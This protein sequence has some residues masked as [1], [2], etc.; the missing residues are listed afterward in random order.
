M[1]ELPLNWNTLTN[2]QR[3]K[4]CEAAQAYTS[5]P[6]A[7]AEEIA[8]EMF[9]AVLEAV[10]PAVAVKGSNPMTD[11][12]DPKQ[13][14]CTGEAGS[15]VWNCAFGTWSSDEFGIE[16]DEAVGKGERLY[17]RRDLYDQAVREART[18]LAP[19]P[20]SLHAD[21]KAVDSFADAMKRKL[22]ISRE[23]KS[24]SGW[25]T[26]ECDDEFLAHELIEHL[27]K[28]NTGTF[29]DVA[30]FAMMLHQRGA[31][32]HELAKAYHSAQ[33]YDPRPVSVEDAAR[34]VDLRYQDIGHGY[35]PPM[36]VP[37]LIASLNNYSQIMPDFHRA[38]NV[39]AQAAKL[40]RALAEQ[41]NK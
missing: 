40:L 30:N 10:R 37:N 9:Y 36:D 22:K 17:V 3:K 34:K 14:V 16:S 18:D 25:N 24:K 31:S 20:A 33:A 2:D 39:M 29:E 19:R 26:S 7:G 21:D 23:V 41:A 8:S 27:C 12:T 28:G 11:N 15:D 1:G 38:Q 13:I 4:I 32:P 35:R 5:P 6:C